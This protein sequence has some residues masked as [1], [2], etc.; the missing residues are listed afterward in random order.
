[1]PLCLSLF[2]EME[3]LK[4]IQLNQ[5]QRWPFKIPVELEDVCD[6]MYCFQQEHLEINQ[7]KHQ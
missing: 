6:A 1:M 4:Y 3:F 7:E 5:L 2:V